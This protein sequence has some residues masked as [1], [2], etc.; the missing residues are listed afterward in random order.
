MSESSA[1]P[2]SVFYP[3]LSLREVERLLLCSRSFLNYCADNAPY[4]YSPYEK[5][6]K[7]GVG[8]RTIDNPQE[9]LKSLQSQIKKSLLDSLPLP[10]FIKG[11]VPGRSLRQHASLHTQRAAVVSLDL[12][13]FFGSVSSTRVRAVFHEVFGATPQVL[14]LLVR[15]TTFREHLPQGSPTSSA[16]A[17]LAVIPMA[18]EIDLRLKNND[19]D[20][21][22]SMWCDDITMSGTGAQDFIRDTV[23]IVKR[24]GFRVNPKKIDIMPSH[25]PQIVTGFVVNKFLS[26]GSKRIGEVMRRI[27]SMGSGEDSTRLRSLL[28]H[29]RHVNPTQGNKLLQLYM[30]TKAALDLQ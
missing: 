5:P 14:D 28:Y 13:D 19:G 18:R 17:N 27:L 26:Y 12:K 22:F 11:G 24:H 6:K 25:G 16:L 4:M 1:R 2:R 3:L 9:P 21:H 30:K 20:I 29:I 23:G 8:T 7:N 15:L 10:R